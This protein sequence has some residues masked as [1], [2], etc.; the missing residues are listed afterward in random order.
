MYT[1]ED[2]KVNVE[3]ET[4]YVFITNVICCL[5]FL[6]RNDTSNKDII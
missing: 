3:N 5:R 1:A 6:R 2:I 4:A